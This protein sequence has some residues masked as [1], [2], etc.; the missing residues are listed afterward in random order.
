LS[1]SN[2]EERTT[3]SEAIRIGEIVGGDIGE[4]TSEEE[5]EVNATSPRRVLVLRIPTTSS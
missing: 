2:Q 4:E 1:I 5:G 3:N